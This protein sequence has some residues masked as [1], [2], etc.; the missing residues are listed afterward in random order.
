MLDDLTAVSSAAPITA[1]GLDPTGGAVPGQRDSGD[2]SHGL[3]ASAEGGEGLAPPLLPPSS[4]SQAS[5]TLPTA[6]AATAVPESPM[7]ARSSDSRGDAG[8]AFGFA[9][10][11][12]LILLKSYL[13]CFDKDCY[14]G[15]ISPLFILQKP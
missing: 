14:Q 8:H 10:V 7:S 12:G 2:V 13:L 11:R 3:H 9:A 15:L 4:L 5:A 1:N 6:S